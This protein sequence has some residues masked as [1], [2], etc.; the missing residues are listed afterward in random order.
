MNKKILIFGLPILALAV[1]SAIA[2]YALFSAT[3]VVSQPIAITGDLEQDLSSVYSGDTIIG[4]PITI[5]NDAE[6]SRELLITDDSG[7]DI[8]VVYK[9]NLELTHK[10]VDFSLDVWEIIAGKVQIQYVLVGEEFLAEVTAGSISGYE[11][12]YYKDNSDRFNS[13]AEAISLADV[14]GNLAYEND[15]NN[16]E[17][18]YC[19]TLE[20]LTCHGAKIWYVPSDA[21][22]I[23]GNLDWSRTSEF[24]FETKLIQFNSAGKIVIYGGD[25]IVITPEYTPNPYISGEYIIETTVA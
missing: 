14:S 16:D 11:L 19:S 25:S 24:Y 10:T 9:S 6:T 7:E 12:I 20:Y 3:F 2:Y 8:D 22:D 17:Y 4:T 23:S 21:I 15:K 5:S 18:D 1:V 13:P